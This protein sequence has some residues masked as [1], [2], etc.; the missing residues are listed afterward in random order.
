LAVLYSDKNEFE[1]A[2]KAY[3]RALEIRERLYEKYPEVY[4]IDVAQT[5]YNLS[6]FYRDCLISREKSIQ[7]IQKTILILIPIAEQVPY[8]QP[9]LKASVNILQAWDFDVQVWLASLEGE[10]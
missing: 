4:L 5:N 8:V 10:L 6:L 7:C 2:E 3:L 1:K 9:Y